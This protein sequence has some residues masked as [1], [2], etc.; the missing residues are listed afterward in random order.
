MNTAVKI[1]NSLGGSNKAIDLITKT[2]FKSG[3]QELF[4]P[5]APRITEE[6]KSKY[7]MIADQVINDFEDEKCKKNS[8]KKFRN[9]F[10]SVL[11]D[12]RFHFFNARAY[13]SLN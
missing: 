7:G 13:H 3:N 4:G 1:K 8:G 5:L 11:F 12:C 6:L 2:S 10:K 9:K